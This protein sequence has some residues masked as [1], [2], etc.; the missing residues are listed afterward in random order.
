MLG[1]DVP[2]FLFGGTAL[3]L[4]R[5][6]ELYP[7]PDQP[8][9]HVLVV[10]TGVHVSTAEAYR[11][12]G[13]NVTGA[14][15]SPVDSPMLREFQAVVWALD[16]RSPG[17]ANLEHLPLENDF[18]QAVFKLHPELA[19]VV[20]K[21]RRLGAKPAMMTGSGSSIFGVFATAEKLRTAAQQFPSARTFPV[22]FINRQQY[23]GRWL[24]ALGP[25]ASAS[26]FIR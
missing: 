20:R 12:L 2:F 19:A 9:H 3:G 13:R 7:L 18:E 14:L 21:L 25:A 24:R 23:R 26:S 5:G 1:S 22:R 17:H 15:T 6:T 8:A 4:G 11:S 16:P 10:S